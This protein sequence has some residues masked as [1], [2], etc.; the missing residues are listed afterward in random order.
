MEYLQGV[1]FPQQTF[2]P[3]EWGQMFEAVMADG[4]LRG[5]S[6]TASG[7][8]VNIAKGAMIIKGRFIAIPSAVAE[9]TSPTYP[10]G[11]GRVKVCINTNNASTE[12]VNR[13]AFVTT[14]Y[15]ST[16]SFPSLTQDDVNDG[17]TLYEAELAVVQYSGGSISSITQTLGPVFGAD[18]LIGSDSNGRLTAVDVNLSYIENISSDVQTQLDSK[19]PR[20]TYG[21]ADPTGGSTG[22][23]YIKYTE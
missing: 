13:Q 19:Q 15:A 11:Y 16:N 2:T 8:T 23:V 18:Q 17:G 7:N 14:E 1:T 9:V 21:T 10:N 20:I 6:V 12:T 5:C 4:I 3:S 22:D